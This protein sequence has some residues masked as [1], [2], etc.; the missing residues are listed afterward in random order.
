MLGSHIIYVWM[1]QFHYLVRFFRAWNFVST[2]N[3]EEWGTNIR[4]GG[5]GGNE[6]DWGLGGKKKGYESV[7][8]WSQHETP[9]GRMS[10]YSWVFG[11]LLCTLSHPLFWASDIPSAGQLANLPGMASIWSTHRATPNY[12]WMSSLPRGS[13][14]VPWWSQLFWVELSGPR[15]PVAVP[16]LP[17]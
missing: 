8:W 13:L 16:E 10:T 15:Q 4:R 11:P 7:G 5:G 1:L 17:F 3:F 14:S 12:H 6:V 9:G 2:T